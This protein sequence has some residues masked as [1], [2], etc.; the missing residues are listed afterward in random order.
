[1]NV[2]LAGLHGD[3]KHLKTLRPLYVLSSFFYVKNEIIEYS[4]TDDC[5]D[6]MLDSG[7][8]SFFGGKDV[9]W[10]KYTDEYI[11]F[12][13]KNDVQKFFEMDIDNLKSTSFAEMLRERIESKTGKQSI[14]VWRPMRGVNYWNN[15]CKEYSYVAISASGMY[16]SKWTRKK[17]SIPAIN[18]M[19]S[20]AHENNCK[21]HGLGFTNQKLL[22]I[23][24]FDSVDST[25]WMRARFGDVSLFDG[26][27]MKIITKRGYRVKSKE[28][29]IN[30]LKEWIKFQKYADIKL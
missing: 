17:E 8:F 6:F 9:D 1:V 4:K 12:I 20:I 26:K 15:M 18:K 13:N 24:K 16:D 3:L 19:I 11:D 21:V 23:I 10:I 5:K 30:N 25:T 28:S 14:P 29:T 27:E 22:K 7:A 2:Y